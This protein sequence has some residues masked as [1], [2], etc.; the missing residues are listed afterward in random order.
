MTAKAEALIASL[1]AVAERCGDPA[2]LVYAR[3]FENH[4]EMEVLFV[5]DT[6]GA[7]RGQMLQQVIE[8]LL[9][10]VGRQSFGV[11]LILSEATNH[12]NL[13]VPPQVFA[14]FFRTVMEAFRAALGEAWLPHYAAAWE[15]ILA[16]LDLALAV[17]LASAPAP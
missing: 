5:R 13:G 14:G 10:L 9:D 6:D 1:E 8:S 12:E 3:L 7:V 15:D 17:R 16:E 11:N 4:P 2:P